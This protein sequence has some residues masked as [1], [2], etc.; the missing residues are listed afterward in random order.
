MVSVP[1]GCACPEL[2]ARHPPVRS[3]S[4]AFAGNNQWS[5]AG[6]RALKVSALV[7]FSPAVVHAQGMFPAAPNAFAGEYQS[8][9]LAPLQRLSPVTD[10]MLADPPPR[11][12]LM[13][14]RTYDG[15]GF[16][17]LRQ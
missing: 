4:S 2:Q 1:L 5:G 7:L 6:R 10:A 11:E 17:P 9:L 12:W 13:W 16:G 15:W 8:R 3:Y 14:R